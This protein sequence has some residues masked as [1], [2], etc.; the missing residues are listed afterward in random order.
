MIRTTLATALL[1]TTLAT[2]GAVAQDT[3]RAEAGMLECALEAN[4][5]A[6]IGSS[7]DMQ[8]VF[9]P[10]D[11]RPPVGFVGVINKFGLDIGVTSAA[12][13]QWA[14]L[15]PTAAELSPAALAG[16]YYGASAEVT[17]AIGGGANIL[18]G[19]SNESF[20]LQPLSVQA[21][22]GLNIALGVTEFKL[23]AIQ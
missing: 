22:T 13:M 19:G 2:T 18:V 3:T 4:I 7:R 6:I 5:G 12:V 20:M 23:R 10:S 14:V 16:D 1:A 21:Q 17:A 15:A 9:Q 11:G 8:C